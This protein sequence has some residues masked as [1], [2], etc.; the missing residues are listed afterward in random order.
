VVGK[1]RWS[2]E[3][4]RLLVNGHGIAG[5]TGAPQLATVPLA[6]VRHAR[7][8]AVVGLGAGVTCEVAARRGA[9]VTCIEILP[10][11]IG[12]QPLFRWLRNDPSPAAAP[13]GLRY[14][15]DDGRR[16]LRASTDRYDLIVVDGTQIEFEGGAAL[17]TREFFDVVARRLEPGGLFALWI[18][19][20]L[21]NE[22][23]MERTLLAS[24][25]WVAAKEGSNTMLAGFGPLEE[26]PGPCA[27]FPRWTR[28]DIGGAVQDG[29]ILSDDDPSV[30]FRLLRRREV[31]Q[32]Q[33]IGR[34]P[35]RE[36]KGRPPPSTSPP[37]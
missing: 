37:R 18:G 14:R 2:E 12:V 3:P 35:E 33:R 26:R 16:F 10:S 29:P 5:A 34:I 36:K 1:E 22:H 4:G 25:P 13:P 6:C 20:A 30:M 21:E 23:V 31:E 9:D 27:R 15:L 28:A 8:V 24:F 19:I 11:V 17:L 7:R 32:A